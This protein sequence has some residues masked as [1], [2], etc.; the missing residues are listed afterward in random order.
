MILEVPYL[1]SLFRKNKLPNTNGVRARASV[2]PHLTY[3]N[4]P[5]NSKSS[6]A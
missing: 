5:V 1:A 3:G 4:I 2:S 6:S